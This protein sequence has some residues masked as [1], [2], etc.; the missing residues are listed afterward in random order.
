MHLAHAAAPP[1]APA[2]PLLL[3][4]ILLALLCRC[5]LPVQ[6][7]VPDALLWRCLCTAFV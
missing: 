6:L 4:L 3:L 2:P 1:Q 5:N 7:P